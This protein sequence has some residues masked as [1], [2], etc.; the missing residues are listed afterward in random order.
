MKGYAL[1]LLLIALP[2]HAD[3]QLWLDA[4]GGSVTDD[5][6]RLSLSQDLLLGPDTTEALNIDPDLEPVAGLRLRGE[7]DL[8]PIG[9]GIDLGYARVNHPQADLTLVPTAMGITL[10]ARLT[11]ARSPRF[12]SL[13]P[14]GML[15]IVATGVDGSVNAGTI[16]SEITDNTWGGANGRIGLHASLGLSWQPTPGFAVFSE[17]RYQQMRFHL[18]HTN[19]AVLATQYLQTTGRVDAES[20]LVGISFRVAH[21]PAANPTPAPA[22]PAVMEPEPAAL[23]ASGPASTPAAP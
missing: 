15:G 4:W 2:A 23:P 13:H 20:V 16:N 3:N 17:Y 19:D 18:E 11:L 14:M 6:A 1:P 10:P 22:I 8:L 12:G 5:S 21:A 7:V 9:F